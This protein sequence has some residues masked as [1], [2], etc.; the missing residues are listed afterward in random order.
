MR[1]VG[2][3]PLVALRKAAQARVDAAAEAARLRWVT[4]GVVQQVIYEQKRREAAQLEADPS[5]NPAD[6]PMLS[7]EVGIT[8][9]TLAEVGEVVRGLSAAWLSAAASIEAL[10][11]G[12][13]AAIETAPS[14]AVIATA[15]AVTWPEPS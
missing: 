12:A 8:A 10:R 9:P 14:E 1:I 2:S 7:A 6:Y 4:P 5:P 15:E 11:L 13:K 3:K